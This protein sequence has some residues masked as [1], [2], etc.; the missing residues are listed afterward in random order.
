MTSSSVSPNAEKWSS[1]S[2]GNTGF[3]ANPELLANQIL[4][5]PYQ[6]EIRQ[7]EKYGES[8][9]GPDRLDLYRSFDT[10]D[11]L[12]E[13]H[14]LIASPAN[15]ISDGQTFTLSDGLNSLTFE[16]DDVTISDGVTPG[17]VRIPFNPMM[18][19]FATGDLRPQTARG[20]GGGHSRRDQQPGGAGGAEDHGGPG[21]RDRQ[22]GSSSTNSVI[23][24][25]GNVDSPVIDPALQ[26]TSTT[27]D[28]N[29]LR[30]A[31]LGGVF[32]P[33]GDA[34]F[35]GGSTSAGFFTGG[36]DVDRYL[37]RYRADDR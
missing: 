7:S 31:L 14:S 35:V 22:S 30:D 11:R 37:V 36:G 10:N 2:S 13:S 6:L 5:G 26:V 21:R 4:S 33:V 34:I 9:Q 18:F 24:L 3:Y 29:Q 19:D 15:E 28:G 16:F 27:S 23:N 1:N 25:F 20:S 17:N 32:E 12:S 8:L